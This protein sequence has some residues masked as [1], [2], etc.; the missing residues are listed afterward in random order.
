[1]WVKRYKRWL[2]YTFFSLIM[3]I[4]FLN[5]SFPSDEVAD[6]LERSF[7]ETIPGVALSIGSIQPFIPLG[8]KLKDS[9]F[10]SKNKPS[11]VLFKSE[12]IWISPRYIC[13][14]STKLKSYFKI[15]SYDGE[16]SGTF[17]LRPLV[18][19][20]EIHDFKLD[21]DSLLQY[22]L[23]FRVNGIL[24]AK[25]CYNGDITNL[26]EGRGSAVLELSNGEIQL[27]RPVLTLERIPFKT[28]NAEIGIKG[29]KV[30]ITRFNLKGRQLMGMLEG[31]INLKKRF[32]E[33]TLDIKGRIEPFPAFFIESS[34][35]ENRLKLFKEMISMHGHVS[36]TVSG[37]IKNP[38]VG[39]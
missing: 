12:Y 21:E 23:G 20:I 25:I 24:S 19:D 27:S 16:I 33:S 39:M 28:I 18:L 14:F 22:L 5:L 30:S 34:G 6:S 11:I 17:Q 38:K 3:T 2:G 10:I 8:L 26:L 35:A 37:S 1:V 4:I 32:V 31:I 7:A 15:Y 13:R 29:G 36:F 9:R